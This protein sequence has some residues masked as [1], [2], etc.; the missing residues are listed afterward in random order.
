VEEEKKAKPKEPKVAGYSPAPKTAT[1]TKKGRNHFQGC[2]SKWETRRDI[3]ADKESVSVNNCGFDFT[4][5]N[6]HYRANR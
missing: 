3:D 6:S 4:N 1:G 2:K 5:T